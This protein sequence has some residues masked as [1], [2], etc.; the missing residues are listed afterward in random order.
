MVLNDLQSCDLMNIDEKIK[1]N[2]AMGMYA[3]LFRQFVFWIRTKIFGEE[4]T[5]LQ[6][7]L[8]TFVVMSWFK[9]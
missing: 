6:R 5:T 8:T 4:A 1:V 7:Y 3:L 9:I 2:Y